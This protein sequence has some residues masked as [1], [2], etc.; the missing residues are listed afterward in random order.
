LSD[1]SLGNRSLKVLVLHH[2]NVATVRFRL[3]ETSQAINKD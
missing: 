2:H 1:D 3:V